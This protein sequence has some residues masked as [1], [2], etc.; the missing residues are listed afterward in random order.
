M[1]E[2][3]IL[4]TG[5]SNLAITGEP[6]SVEHR[7]VSVLSVRGAPSALLL[8]CFTQKS[9]VDLGALLCLQDG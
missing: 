3:P 4:Q 5:E 1:V 6:N 8:R 2:V 9:D 7:L